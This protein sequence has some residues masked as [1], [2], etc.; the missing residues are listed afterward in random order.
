MF[1]LKAMGLVSGKMFGTTELKV[2]SP[3]TKCFQPHD[4]KVVAKE[5]VG[6]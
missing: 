3:K 4:L 5:V 1:C 2:V 6:L